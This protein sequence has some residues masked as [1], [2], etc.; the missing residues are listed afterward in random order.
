[1]KVGVF[2]LSHKI[3]DPSG[4]CKECSDWI[5]S[6]FNQGID[7][8]WKRYLEKAWSSSDCQTLWLWCNPGVFRWK[9]C[10]LT[11]SLQGLSIVFGET[12]I[13]FGKI[14]SDVLISS[15]LDPP[16]IVK[17]C[18]CDVTLVCSVH[19]TDATLHYGVT[20]MKHCFW[21]GKNVWV[22]REYFE[23]N[24]KQFLHSG[25]KNALQSKHSD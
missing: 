13:I 10:H 5:E 15:K 24:Q 6:M 18:D 22:R 20:R 9:W 1:M 12:K 8:F 7:H 23:K 11:L 14:I 19:W 4:E 16:R 2:S 21:R 17:F 3:M 25:T